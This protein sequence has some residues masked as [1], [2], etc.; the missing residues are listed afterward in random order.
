MPALGLSRSL[1]TMSIFG[2]VV[3]V[4][5]E[6]PLSS[7]PITLT[8]SQTTLTAN[9]FSASGVRS[10][11]RFNNNNWRTSGQ[12]QATQ[13]FF[14]GLAMTYNA[15]W[16]ETFAGFTTG[17]SKWVVY[18]GWVDDGSPNMDILYYHPTHPDTSIPTS[19]W[20]LGSTFGSPATGGTLAIS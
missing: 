13:G 18:I 20:L 19:G 15:G 2:S 1:P 9:G 3:A 10:L 5:T 17:N 12:T 6:L 14:T 4:A 11:T 8:F 16:P 7:S